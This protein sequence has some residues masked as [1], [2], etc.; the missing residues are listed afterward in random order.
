M[1]RKSTVANHYARL[2]WRYLLNGKVKHA[3]IPSLY[4]SFSEALCGLSPL[5]SSTWYGTG[6]QIEY[7]VVAARPICRMCAAKIEAF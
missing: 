6:S 4:A 2:E 7:E 1:T 5:C 3:L